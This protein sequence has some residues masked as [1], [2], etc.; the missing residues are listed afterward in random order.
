MSWSKILKS[1]K[2]AT[3]HQLPA[4]ILLTISTRIEY[5]GL[6]THYQTVI[7]G[8]IKDVLSTLTRS[9]Q[10]VHINRVF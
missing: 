6:I 5:G 4:G 9:P 3:G 8:T 1:V 7:V 2:N 10:H